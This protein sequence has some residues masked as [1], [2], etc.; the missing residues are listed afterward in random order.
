MTSAKHSQKY[1]NSL[2]GRLKR[3]VTGAKR[4]SKER[5]H[6]FD[7]GEE[8]VLACW[9]AQEG[10]CAYTGWDMSTISGDFRVVSI[11]RIDNSKGYLKD[12]FILVCWCANKARST[13]PLDLF[14]ELCKAV[15]SKHK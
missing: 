12:N 3:L 2:K 13:L 7:I 9:I 6:L 5:G 1:V 14:F 4:S 11:E 10:K 8:D 15:S